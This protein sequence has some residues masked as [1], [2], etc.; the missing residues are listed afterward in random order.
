MAQPLDRIATAP[1]SWGLCEVPGWGVQLPPERVL[2]EMRA[3]GFQATEAGPDGYLGASADEI[4]TLLRRYDLHLIGGF[5]PVVL[6]DPGARADA[7]VS[8]TRVAEHFRSAGASFL[9]SAVVVDME[10]APPRTLSQEEWNRMFDGLAR[11]DE[12]ADVHG[13]THVVHPHWGTLIERRADVWRVL[14][15]SDVRFC[16]DTGHLALG[17]TDP[18]EFAAAAGP[19]VAHVHMKDIDDLI[20]A[21]LRANE[22]GL[23]P[24]V[25]AGLFKPLG[26]GDAPIAETVH[27]LEAAGYDGW[28]VLEQD[29]SVASADLGS[30]VGPA[31]DVRRSRTFLLAL[32]EDSGGR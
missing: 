14:E 17:E 19:R 13:L 15:G 29:T 20:G 8:A 26:D 24:A 4:R 2:P 31:E 23:V 32:L 7:L 11:I 12:I 22:L 25:K 9:V 3:L 28:Y 27:V 10:W 18:A 21:R 1:T 5:L 6:H 30:G 16:L